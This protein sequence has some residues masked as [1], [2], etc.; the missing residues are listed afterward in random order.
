MA[1]AYFLQSAWMR[2]LREGSFRAGASYEMAWLST[3]WDHTCRSHSFFLQH[4]ARNIQL[5]SAMAFRSRCW[6]LRYSSRFVL[7]SCCR[8]EGLKRSLRN[9]ARRKE[10]QSITKSSDSAC[11]QFQFRKAALRRYPIYVFSCLRPVLAWMHECMSASK[12]P[13]VI[14]RK[15]ITVFN[16]VRMCHT[17]NL[18]LLWEC[19][20]TCS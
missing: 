8:R 19:L 12:A 1:A 5:G 3:A 16:P 18:H 7:R 17:P 13:L 2:S 14:A 6:E 10:S 20:E 9:S 4:I 11:I 15:V